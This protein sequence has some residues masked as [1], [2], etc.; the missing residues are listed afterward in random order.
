[1]QGVDGRLY[2]NQAEVQSFSPDKGQIVEG[3][4]SHNKRSQPIARFVSASSQASH[5]HHRVLFNCLYAC[6]S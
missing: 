1:M 5:W 6:L 2:F 4:V 3:I